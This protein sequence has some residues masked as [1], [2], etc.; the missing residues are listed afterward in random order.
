[1]SPRQRL[2]VIHLRASAGWAYCHSSVQFTISM[3]ASCRDFRPGIPIASQV[4][5]VPM[6]AVHCQLS[7]VCLSGISPNCSIYVSQRIMKAWKRWKGISRRPCNDRF[8]HT[9][10]K[11]RSP[12]TP[13]G[14]QQADSSHSSLSSEGLFY[15]PYRRCTL[16]VASSAW[17][18]ILTW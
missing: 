15:R 1:M 12:V 7:F 17:V 5:G 4:V 13:F 2:I 9:G 10:A 16:L 11:P 3:I 18:C 6:C 14:S 8:A